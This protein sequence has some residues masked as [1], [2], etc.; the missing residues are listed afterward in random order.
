MAHMTEAQKEE[1]KKQIKEATET[2]LA[3]SLFHAATALTMAQSFE[4]YICC[5]SLCAALETEL[6][7]RG[8]V[9]Q[10]LYTKGSPE[11]QEIISQLRSSYAH[12]T[13]HMSDLNKLFPIN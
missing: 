4:Q 5:F 1:H 12:I 13:E 3:A 6:V 11:A 8:V 7:E 2:Q 9:S 10:P